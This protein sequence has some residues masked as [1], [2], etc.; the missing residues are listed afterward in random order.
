[1][2]VYEWGAQQYVWLPVEALHYQ[3]RYSAI[4]PAKQVVLAAECEFT[5]AKDLEACK[6]RMA[7]N[8]AFRKAH[9]PI[10]PNGGSVFRNPEATAPKTT[11]EGQA[12]LSV[13][14]MVEALG[15]KGNWRYGDA[16]VSPLHG[17]F[18][19]N[20]GHATCSDVL[21]V[22]LRMK[23]EIA[24][25]YGVEIFPENRLLGDVNAEEQALWQQLKGQ[26]THED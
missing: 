5:P 16:M 10:Q 13:G 2:L 8:M 14:Q 24:K 20:L 3:Y 17:N 26:D 1:V 15:G 18:I 7:A 22:M 23:T 21:Q 25:A 6:A 12:A 19:V 9:H 11:G 4:A